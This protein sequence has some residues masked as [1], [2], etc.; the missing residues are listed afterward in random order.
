M[1]YSHSQYNVP[2][3]PTSTVFTPSHSFSSPSS[4]SSPFH[5]PPDPANELDGTHIDTLAS[6]YASVQ[7]LKQDFDMSTRQVLRAN[8]SFSS[9]ISELR[10]LRD[11]NRELQSQLKARCVISQL[12]WE[13]SY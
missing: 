2:N 12:C 6:R 1:A 5:S 7:K 8:E 11:E 9:L 10:V 3:T 13:C 4:L